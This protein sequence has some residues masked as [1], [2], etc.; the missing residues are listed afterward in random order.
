MAFSHLLK[1]V[2]PTDGGPEIKFFDI[3]RLG[4]EFQKLPFSIRILLESAVRNCDNFQVLE[5]DVQK[6]LQW[7]KNQ[8]SMEIP[9]RPA[10]VIL[11]DFTGVPAVVDFA[12]MRDAVA[13][14]G[15]DPNEVNPKCPADLVID[16]SVQVDFVRTPEAK[17]KNEAMEMERNR[18]RFTFLKWGA[19]AFDNMLIVPPGSGIVHQV[20]LEYLA[21]VCFT[22]GEVVYPDSVVGTDSHTTMINGLGVLGWGVGGIEA[23]AV[24]LGQPISMVLPKVVG[25]KITGNIDPYVTSTDLVLTITKHLRQIGVVGQFVEF[26]GPGV[27]ALSIAD[28]AT[29]ANMCPEYGATAAFFPPDD[30]SITY[31]EQTN[32]DAKTIQAIDAYLKASGL[33]RNYSDEAQ[34]PTFSTVVEL[35]LATVVPSCSGPKRPHDRVAV[36]EMKSDFLACLDNPVGFKGFGIAN[37]KL[38][39]TVPFVLDG[40]EYTLNHGSV[41]IAA[42]T[43]CTNTSN[44]SVMLGAGLLAQKAVEKGLKVAPYIKTSLSPGSGVVTYYLQESGVV[45]A[46]DAL[47][48]TN[49]GYGCMTCIG[50]SGPLEE[51]ISEAVKK[52]DLV[53]CG[54][55]S[56]NRN[57]EGRIHP[58]TRANYLASPPLVIAYALAGKVDIDFETEALGFDAE[59]KPI[60]L[61]DI[62][63]TR[64]EIQA[65]ER[66]VVIPQMFKEVYEKITTGNENWNK[67]QAPEGKLYPWDTNSTYIKS[68]PFFEGMTKDLPKFS[69]IEKASIL[70]NLGDSV[71]TDHI[72]PAG[73]IA[74]TSP[75]ARFLQSRGVVP[76]EFNSY[77]SRRGNDAI[78]ARGT[79]ANIRLVNKLN[80]GKAGPKTL[81][82]PSN[83]VVD[84]FDAAEKY[85]QAG[86]PLMILAGKDYG[87]GSSRDWAA[88]GPF[89]L[90]VKAVLAESYERIHRSNL[91]GM[92]IIPLQY[93]DGDTAESLGL[94][95]LEKFSVVLPAS[96]ED[97]KP[98]QNVTV[99]VEGET[100]KSFEAIMR[101]DTELELT[102]YKHGGILNYMI[103]KVVS[104]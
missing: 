99:K 45:P 68:P 59:N 91:V 48:F 50:N 32:R 6:I 22:K 51:P 34:D 40:Q 2:T 104:Q 11:Q 84:V 88:K 18:E 35:D 102:Y 58:D 86:T 49:V 47:G 37:D 25:Y 21:R 43:S 89:L 28:R 14:L 82:I 75:A 17:A 26:F 56:G 80:G 38:N 69:A 66:K 63:P 30:A 101:F 77:G 20:N 36:K 13:K 12:A 73:S 76:R 79:F 62:W 4:E 81:H 67:L 31:L 85:H 39:T 7:E 83:E 96:A 90:G 78:M 95:G 97:L 103:R 15:G 94:T 52:G 60:F 54:V 74:R 61:R 27:A 71:T 41:L 53:C 65:V 24:M 33:K 5:A 44:P 23:E 98:R 64:E 10:R 9:F 29:I 87:S 92:G 3:A 42:I 1:S 55:L 57:F 8:G 70:L 19:T 46:L 16:H 93:K 100:E 72:S